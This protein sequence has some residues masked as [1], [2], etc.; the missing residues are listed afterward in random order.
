MIHE[1]FGRAHPLDFLHPKQPP[2]TAQLL[3]PRRGLRSGRAVLVGIG[4]YYAWDA[5]ARR[6]E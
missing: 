4:A 2:R 1:H 3:S 6:C 5:N